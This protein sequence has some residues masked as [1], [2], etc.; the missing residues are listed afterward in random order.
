M[1]N[2][3]CLAQDDVDSSGGDVDSNEVDDNDVGDNNVTDVNDVNDD[4]QGGRSDLQQTLKNSV[5]RSG[6][7]CETME[8]I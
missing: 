2:F 7:T 3:A 4:G 1:S 5:C 6:R 8:R